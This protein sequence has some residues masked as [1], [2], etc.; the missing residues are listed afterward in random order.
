VLFLPDGVARQSAI[1]NVGANISW[2]AQLL[3]TAQQAARPAVPARVSQAIPLEPCHGRNRATRL[4]TV[5]HLTVNNIPVNFGG[6]AFYPFSRS[7]PRG[8]LL[9]ILRLGCQDRRIAFLHAFGWRD[10]VGRNCR[11]E[12][13][14]TASWAWFAYIPGAA[15]NGRA[16]SLDEAKKA[17]RA[18]WDTRPE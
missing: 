1:E 5:T 8:V 3:R 12:G 11:V 13:A 10:R 6:D 15:A 16:L 2:Q 18:A 7:Q 17:F 4:P 14:R 9:Q